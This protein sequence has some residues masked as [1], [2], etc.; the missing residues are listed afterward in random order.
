MRCT[1]AFD[2]IGRR[3]FFHLPCSLKSH[4][5]Q[6]RASARWPFA[7]NQPFQGCLPRETHLHNGKHDLKI[8][9]RGEKPCNLRMGSPSRRIHHACSLHPPH[10]S[11]PP[12]HLRVPSSTRAGA[13]IGC[14]LHLRGRWCAF[15]DEASHVGPWSST[16]LPRSFPPCTPN[17]GNLVR[18]EP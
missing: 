6:R 13:S 11:I 3:W 2:S 4:P 14:I 12:A 16:V 9:S 8:F 17:A 7:L 15:Q 1:C 18:T 10:L 5:L